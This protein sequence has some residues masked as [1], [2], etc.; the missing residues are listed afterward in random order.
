MRVD[1]GNLATVVRVSSRGIATDS[2]PAVLGTGLPAVATVKR[3]FVPLPATAIDGPFWGFTLRVQVN[4]GR[5]A[6]DL[7]LATG[8]PPGIPQPRRGE[9]LAVLV[10][11]DDPRLLAVDWAGS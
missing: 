11:R 8:Y 10:S 2:G 4:D 5:P 3:V 6:Y 7:R 9:R 1:P